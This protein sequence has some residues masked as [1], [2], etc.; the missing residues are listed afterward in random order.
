MVSELVG[1]YEV[2]TDIH[3]GAWLRNDK[4]PYTPRL[5]EL[6]NDDPYQQKTNT[7]MSQLAWG[8][9]V[10]TSSFSDN[11]C[12]WATPATKGPGSTSNTGG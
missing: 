10:R 12:K 7:K 4:D 11:D 2:F 3:E 1:R 6:E 5:C 8:A 9:T